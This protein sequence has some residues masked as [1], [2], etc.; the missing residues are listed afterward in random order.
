MRRVGPWGALAAAM[1][2]LMAPTL[3]EPLPASPDPAAPTPGSTAAT[4][5]TNSWGSLQE[6]LGLPEWLQLQLEIQAEPMANPVGGQ[7]SRASWIQQST[8]QIDLLPWR[9]S[10]PEASRWS[11]RAE[12]A[13]INGNPNYAE[14]IGAVIPLQQL[15]DPLGFWLSA[16]EIRRETLPGSWG[17]RAG[18]L[19][20][21]PA[22]FTAPLASYYVHGALNTAPGLGTADFPVAPLHAP[23]AVLSLR[24]SEELR[25][26]VA[27][28]DLTAM[29]AQVRRFG[30]EGSMAG[31]GGW[32]QMVQLELTPSWLHSPADAP[33]MPPSAPLQLPPGSLQLGGYLGSGPNRGLYS[34]LS[35]PVGSGPG[36]DRRLWFAAT[37][38]LDPAFNAIR[39][40]LS[41]GV[42]VLGPFPGRPL[43]VLALGMARTG[44]SPGLQ[45]QLDQEGV[46]ELGYQ[47]HLNDNLNLQPTLQWIVNPGARGAW[48][49]ILSSGLQV[50][51]TF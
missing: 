28:F 17:L 22:F 41:T 15:A 34:S 6:W 26:D 16:A 27:G 43:D 40:N 24:P 32:L 36:S 23:G 10:S 20:L 21:D 31:P 37:L 47:L 35:L 30:I 19:S 18:L 50:T 3:A 44:F 29:A 38:G 12:L 2:L 39:T 5:Q 45:P 8:L 1:A 4:P 48:P 42:V 51:L 13:W 25:L 7:A 46:V 11:L 33:S 14:S 9:Q 49:G